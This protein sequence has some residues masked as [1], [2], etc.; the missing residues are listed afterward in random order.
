M[1]SPRL[2]GTFIYR[3]IW[4]RRMVHNGRRIVMSLLRTEQRTSSESTMALPI[5][6]LMRHSS[7]DTTICYSHRANGLSRGSTNGSLATTH[8][9]KVYSQFT[10]LG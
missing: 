1:L 6:E 8:T 2:I 7:L 4:G 10:P 9:L 3:G 5:S